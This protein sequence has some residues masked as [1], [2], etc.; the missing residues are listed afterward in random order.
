MLQIEKPKQ[1]G[2]YLGTLISVIGEHVLITREL[3]FE[4]FGLTVDNRESNSLFTHHHPSQDGVL[5]NML[6]TTFLEFNLVRKNIYGQNNLR[7]T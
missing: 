2:F 5:H 1:K 4:V 3:K 7:I 6:Q